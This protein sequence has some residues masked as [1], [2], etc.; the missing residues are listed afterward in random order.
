MKEYR[1]V[2]D[3]YA[4]GDPYT[5]NTDEGLD[6]KDCFVPSSDQYQRKRMIPG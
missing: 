4:L 1:T 6:S 5:R 2:D 3:A